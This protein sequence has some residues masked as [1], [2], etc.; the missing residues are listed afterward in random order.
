MEP[1]RHKVAH[2]EACLREVDDLRKDVV[3]Y[4]VELA[5]H[6]RSLEE[7][8]Q[9]HLWVTSDFVDPAKVTLEQTKHDV[10]MLLARIDTVR[11]GYELLPREEPP[12]PD[13]AVVS[14]S[15]A[16]AAAGTKKG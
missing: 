15:A 11:K 10:E 1:T 8:I 3:A 13:A 6:M 2:V 12:P 9:T 16:P 7:D 5:K 14:P 4:K